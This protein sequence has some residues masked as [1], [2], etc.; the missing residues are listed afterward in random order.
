M[1]LYLLFSPSFTLL[2]AKHR[3]LLKYKIVS[4]MAGLSTIASVI[5][6]IFLVVAM[7]DDFE[8]RVLGSTVTLI[9]FYFL[10]IYIIFGKGKI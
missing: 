6:S 4:L 3:Q 9:I 10:H 2:Q 1:F 5:I 8:A 7:E